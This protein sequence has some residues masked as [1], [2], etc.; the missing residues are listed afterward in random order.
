MAGNKTWD[1]R[2]LDPKSNLLAVLNTEKLLHATIFYGFV[3]KKKSGGDRKNQPGKSD[4]R[5]KSILQRK[6]PVCA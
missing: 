5:S 1:S 4:V 3:E 6:I 2:S